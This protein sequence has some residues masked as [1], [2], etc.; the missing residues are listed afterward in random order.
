MSN[1]AETLR[2]TFLPLDT[3]GG[4]KLFLKYDVTFKRPYSVETR[5]QVFCRVSTLHKAVIR[6]EHIIEH[7]VA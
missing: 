7:G 4:T 1:K 6:Y 3:L 5:W 2:S